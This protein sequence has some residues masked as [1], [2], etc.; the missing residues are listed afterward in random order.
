VQPREVRFEV[1]H[2]EV[3]QRAANRGFAG[4]ALALWVERG[5]E[6]IG[7][8]ACPRGNGGGT[9]LLTEER[10]SDDTKNKRPFQLLAARVTWVGH[11][12]TCGK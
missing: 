3:P 7:M 1:P 4:Y 10:T 9:A 6:G 12:G 5:D 11:S 8:R 2:V